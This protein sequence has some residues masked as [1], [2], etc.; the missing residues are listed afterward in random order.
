MKSIR[1]NPNLLVHTTHNYDKKEN[2]TYGYKQV[3]L[4]LHSEKNH[5][6]CPRKV[7]QAIA[8]TKNTLKQQ[9]YCMTMTKLWKRQVEALPEGTVEDSRCG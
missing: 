8:A 4:E 3:L 6:T 9:C 1:A 7:F 2:V 5:R